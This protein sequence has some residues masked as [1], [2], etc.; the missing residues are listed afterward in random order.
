MMLHMTPP[1][2][3]LAQTLLS[4]QFDLFSSFGSVAAVARSLIRF[5][6][7]KILAAT[8]SWDQHYV[9]EVR[10]VSTASRG[11]EAVKMASLQRFWKS[12]S[13][14]IPDQAGE[15][16]WYEVV[17]RHVQAWRSRDA[18]EAG[19]HDTDNKRENCKM[20]AERTDASEW[21]WGG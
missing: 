4:S 11:A 2:K 10:A 7:F 1:Q 21:L 18:A 20:I 5:Q 9:N 19:T 13:L 14:Q 15:A 6:D 8:R 17:C 16:G 12:R 3:H